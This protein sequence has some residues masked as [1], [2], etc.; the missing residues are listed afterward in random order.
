MGIAAFVLWSAFTYPDTRYLICRKVY[1]EL[2][3]TTVVSLFKVA[4]EM[5]VDE[6][7]RAGY[8]QQR[9]VITLPN[10]SEILFRHVDPADNDPNFTSLRDEI[11]FAAIDEAGEVEEIVPQVLLSRI[12]HNV[13]PYGP[14]VLL[15]CNPSRNFCYQIFDQYEKGILPPH[16][17]YL[18]ATQFDNGLL[19]KWTK[20]TLVRENYSEAYWES[21]IMGNWRYEQSDTMLFDRSTIE[22]AFTWSNEGADQKGVYLTWDCAWGGDDVSCVG[23]WRGMCLVQC[24]VWKKLDPEIQY[25]NV[26]KLISDYHIPA[27]HVSM[28]GIG[29]A[30][31]VSRFR[32]CIDHRANAR[33]MNQEAF[34]QLKDQLYF[35]LS[36]AF[37][38]HE[39]RLGAC[40]VI[41]EDLAVELLAIKSVNTSGEKNAAI[42][43]K[44]VIKRSIGRST[45]RADMLMQRMYWTYIPK[46]FAVDVIE[47]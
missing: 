23:V 42:N 6:V 30:S 15:C 13:P 17:R 10:K 32:G 19:D 33:P 35:R 3:A 21:M 45:D 7:L 46:G 28:D 9:G 41:K 43:S 36:Q 11:S 24:E 16:W 34:V 12:R 47:W 37:K 8:N 20:A 39:L 38:D 40:P 22:D 27:N 44:E 14:T 18:H 4:T 2:I 31:M 25:A 29:A 26:K 1:K 5:G